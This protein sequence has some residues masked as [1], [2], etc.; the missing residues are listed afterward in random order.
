MVDSVVTTGVTSLENAARVEVDV[1]SAP[2]TKRFVARLK[3]STDINEALTMSQL[4]STMLEG[5]GTVSVHELAITFMTSASG[6][7]VTAGVWNANYG[8]SI[9]FLRGME[10]VVSFVSNAMNMG[11]KERV[12]LIIPSLFSSLIQPVSGRHPMMKLYVQASKGVEVWVELKVLIHQTETHFFEI[13]CAG[14]TV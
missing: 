14:A 11:S 10:H 8:K 6:Q 4:C 12:T 9:D 1:E 2:Y 3:S 13:T 7:K 5:C